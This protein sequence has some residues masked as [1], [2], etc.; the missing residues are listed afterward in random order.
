MTGNP[1]NADR[2]PSLSVILP[3]YNEAGNLPHLL[4][5][6]RECLCNRND[7]EVI[8]VDNGSTD[9]SPVV[10]A[11]ALRDPA[12]SRFA[13]SVR[14][15]VN[16]GYGFGIM[17]GVRA[18]TGDVIAWTHADLQ[19][20]PQDV[21]NAFDTY[22][23]LPDCRLAI[24][25]GR[26]IDRPWLDAFFTLGMSLVSSLALGQRLFDVNAQPKMFHR[27]FLDRMKRPPDDFSLDLYALYVARKDGL[28]IIEHPVSFG[29]RRHGVAKGGGT[30]RGKWNLIRRTWAY[31]WKLRARERRQGD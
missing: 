16:Q 26:R 13:R 10:L 21:L 11:A 3:C 19:T 15:P 27:S 22:S 5:R 2:K 14:V 23:R 12:N 28:A 4:S 25:K 20:D 31:L 1:A 9:T 30:L 18:A 24:L 8:L 17:T 7:I 6:F 29:R